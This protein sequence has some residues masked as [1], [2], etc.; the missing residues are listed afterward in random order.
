[1][2]FKD[3]PYS[4]GDVGDNGYGILRTRAVEDTRADRGW[5]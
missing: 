1:M 4:N 5:V 3:F 2:G